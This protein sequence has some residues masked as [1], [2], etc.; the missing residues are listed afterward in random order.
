MDIEPLMHDMFQ[1]AQPGAEPALSQALRDFAPRILPDDVVEI[2]APEDNKPQAEFFRSPDAE[3]MMPL[4]P[5]HSREEHAPTPVDVEAIQR[6]AFAAGEE[7][8]RAEMTEVFSA[9]IKELEETHTAQ[10]TALE[11]ETN[12]KLATAMESSI[13]DG[14]RRIEAS[15]SAQIADILVSF[16]RDELTQQAVSAFATRIASEALS[17]ETPLII[18]GNKKLLEVF[19]GLAGYNP[20]QY[21][22]KP[23]DDREIRMQNGDHVL[24]TRLAPLL[25]ELKELI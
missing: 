14:L 24:S 23:T 16:M 19:E 25:N 17:A 18:D 15:L 3:E 4:E 20:E 10:F 5:E 6:E 7:K 8:Q 22:L 12:V 2:L 11:N 9:R 13:A 1:S 21:R